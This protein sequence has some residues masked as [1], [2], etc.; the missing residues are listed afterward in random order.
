MQTA[1]PLGLRVFGP[2]GVDASIRNA[3]ADAGLEFVRV[4][5]HDANG[6]ARAAALAMLFEQ[7]AEGD[8]SPVFLRIDLYILG[9]CDALP[10][11]QARQFWRVRNFLRRKS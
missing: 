1:D 7:L 6:E 5:G 3:P 8:S 4:I 11:S 2:D 10:V 9:L